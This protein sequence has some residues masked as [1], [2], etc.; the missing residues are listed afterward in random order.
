MENNTNI[1]TTNET[2]A[3]SVFEQKQREAKALASSDLI[4]KQFVNNV[5]NCMIA[6]E[7]AQRMN[8]PALM[9]LQNLDIIH[10]KPSFSAK[11]LI[12]TVNTCGKF[13]PL[14]YR[15]TGERGT[16]SW[17]CIAYATDL[18]TGEEIKGIEVTIG[19]AKKDGWYNK[20][21]SKWQT[22]PELMLHYRAG[23]FFSRL[24]APEIA[25][26]MQT[27]EEIHDITAFQQSNSLS[28]KLQ[29]MKPKEEFTEVEEVTPNE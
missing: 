7:L 10:G 21:G 11:F 20:T 25:M 29:D 13:S 9:V 26:G 6:L 8:V 14:R 17:G 15:E 16:D 4:P 5:A 27:T 22:M 28:S 24:Y 23:T 12:S 18:S 19:M 3:V 1:T 2:N